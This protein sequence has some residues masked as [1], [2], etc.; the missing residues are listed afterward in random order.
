MVLNWRFVKAVSPRLIIPWGD[1]SLIQPLLGPYDLRPE[2]S[3]VQTQWCAGEIPAGPLLSGLTWGLCQQLVSQVCCCVPPPK[4]T[5]VSPL[6][7]RQNFFSFNQ[8]FFDFLIV[9]PFQETSFQGAKKT[10]NV[11]GQSF[12]WVYVGLGWEQ[13][14]GD[15]L[16]MGARGI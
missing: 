6:S 10:F 13:N 5:L 9:E 12:V 3:W 4:K 2:K 16:L 15:G 1:G 14:E 7:I 8:F 11:K